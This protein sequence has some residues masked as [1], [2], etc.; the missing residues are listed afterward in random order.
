MFIAKT[1]CLTIKRLQA[2]AYNTTR[3]KALEL[4]VVFGF[5]DFPSLT[6]RKAM[7]GTKGIA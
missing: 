5:I 3:L 7:N 4:L 2:R 6:G 1:V